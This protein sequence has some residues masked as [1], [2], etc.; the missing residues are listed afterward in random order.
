[1]K[2]IN[3]TTLIESIEFH[4]VK[5]NTP[6]LLCLIDMDRLGVYYN[7]IKDIFTSDNMSMSVI[8][9]FGHSFL[10][11]KET[12]RLY[13]TNSFDFNLCCLTDTKLRQLHRRFDH[14]FALKLRRILKQFDH[15]F[16]KI[17]LNK[18]TE[19]CTFCQKH[20]RL[21]ER[22]KFILRQDVNFNY[23]IIVDIMYIDNEPILHV[24]DEVTRFQSARW[25]ANIN[26][27][28]TWNTLQLC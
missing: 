21:F 6:F 26:V 14:S 20:G 22:F 11:W 9:R 24:I 28:H 16:I 17:A 13:I 15:D 8:R 25:L 3:V 5:I 7:N 12:L 2:S 27:R 18:L 1:M 4:V 10:L 23:S 19:Y